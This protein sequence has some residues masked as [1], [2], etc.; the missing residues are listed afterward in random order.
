MNSNDDFVSNYESARC[1]YRF[2]NYEQ[3]RNYFESALT[4]SNPRDIQAE[5]LYWEYSLCL[6]KNGDC[7]ESL[8]MIR[9]GLAYYP[10]CPELYHIQGQIYYELGLLGQSRIKFSKCTALKATPAGCLSDKNVSDYGAYWFLTAIAARQGKS[11]EVFHYLR[12]FVME[13]PPFSALLKLCLLLL[14]L[15]IE[16][17]TLKNNLVKTYGISS[18]VFN[19]LL[20]SI[21]EN[22]ARLKA[23]TQFDENSSLNTEVNANLGRQAF[24]RGCLIDAKV[25]LER[26]LSQEEESSEDLGI[27]AIACSRLGMYEQALEYFLRAMALDPKNRIYPCFAFEILAIQAIKTLV[28]RSNSL[29]ESPVL[30]NELL[31]LCTI[32]R[33]SMQLRQAIVDQSADLERLES[34]YGRLNILSI[35]DDINEEDIWSISV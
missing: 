25:L 29:E 26:S 9:Q 19:R 5:S 2:G 10:D 8:K 1:C 4:L 33:K 11:D 16:T 23:T 12:L 13:E 7:A 28:Q 20:L 21:K 35:V 31:R 32:K 15:G 3:S 18:L 34:I 24:N 22:E 27:L 14:H 30:I 17:Q 6:Y